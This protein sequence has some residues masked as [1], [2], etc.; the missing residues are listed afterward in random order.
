MR[1]HVKILLIG[2]IAVVFLYFLSYLY[3]IPFRDLWGNLFVGLFSVLVIDQIVEKSKSELKLRRTA[4]SR[5]YVT[6]RILDAY[7]NLNWFMHP[8][9]DWKELLA[10]PDSRAR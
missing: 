7:M 1:S 9:K 10:K 3:N 2:L 5:N 8:P 4:R 6:R